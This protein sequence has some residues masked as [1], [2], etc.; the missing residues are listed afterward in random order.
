MG[1]AFLGYKHPLMPIS[2]DKTNTA[3]KL[4]SLIAAFVL[5]LLVNTS[6][7]VIGLVVV[8][9]TMQNVISSISDDFGDCKVVKKAWKQI[10]W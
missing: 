4:N 2:L 7:T 10:F 1:S 9:P 5:L 8:S 6:V 3:T